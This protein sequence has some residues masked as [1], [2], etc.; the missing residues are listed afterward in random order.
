MKALR[1][2][3]LLSASIP[4][5]LAGCQK[6]QQATP[7][8][9]GQAA[10]QT[11]VSRTVVTAPANSQKPAQLFVF[12]TTPSTAKP[13]P[14]TNINQGEAHEGSN[15]L[16]LPQSD[17]H[18][19]LLPAA[20]TALEAALSGAS[21]NSPVV[22]TDESATALMESLGDEYRNSCGG[23]VW[24]WGPTARDTAKWTVR[25]LYS[26][27]RPE[28]TEAVLALRCA[29][30]G[31]EPYYDE[32]P[33]VVSLTS[34]SAA[35]Q[36]VPLAKGESN[37][38]TLFRLEFSQAFTAVGARLVELNV[39]H[40]SDNPCC[41]GPDSES[42]NRLLTLDLANGKQVLAVD[43]MTE[44]D[45]DDDSVEDGDTH[46]VCEAKMSY[47]N[48]GA[49]NVDS[50]SAETHCKENDKPLPD[51]KRQTFRWNPEAHQFDQVK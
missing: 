36:L 40:S 15:R 22:L 7:Q 2:L 51:V 18:V 12:S 43:Q 39:Y 1:I 48:D 8:K 6:P 17:E 10:A 50:I 11:A 32:R 26:W 16:D 41:G 49:G 3:P 42:G 28:G 31:Q 24:V 20:R 5:L 45:D 19:V 46:T 47:V 44:T 13:A 34:G 38:S 23:L 30:Q 37:D 35:L 29:A 27:R 9:S 21:G 14:P 33:A 4:L 25:V